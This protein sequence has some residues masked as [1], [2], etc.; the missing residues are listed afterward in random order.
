MK[1]PPRERPVSP[2]R[3]LEGHHLAAAAVAVEVA[4][5]VAV[6]VVVARDLRLKASRAPELGRGRRAA[7]V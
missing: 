6:A 2:G 5:E 4:V 1:R 3:F 7:H